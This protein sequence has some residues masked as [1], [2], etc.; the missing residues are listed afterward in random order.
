M[1]AKDVLNNMVR[2]YAAL[3]SY[4]DVGEVTVT[5]PNFEMRTPFSTFCG[6]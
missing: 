2:H 1:D 4:S 5:L 6:K 3:R